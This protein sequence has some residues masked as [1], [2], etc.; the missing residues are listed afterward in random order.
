M[1]PFHFPCFGNTTMHRATI[2]RCSIQL[3]TP[4]TVFSAPTAC[5]VYD[6][7]SF[8]LFVISGALFALE[9]LHTMGMQFFEVAVYSVGAGG[10]CLA[11]YRGLQ[12]EDFGV[13]WNFPEAP[14]STATEVALGAIVGMIAGIV[15]IAF[16]RCVHGVHACSPTAVS[17]RNVRLSI[18]D[19]WIYTV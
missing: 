12:G 10:V 5:L 14:E 9:V 19:G 4:L 11:V 7:R 1:S 2:C 18:A 6:I 13:I 3:P 8:L 16:R 17:Y 15:G